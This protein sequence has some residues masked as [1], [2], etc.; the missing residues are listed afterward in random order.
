VFVPGKPFPDL[1]S[2]S[3]TFVNFVE[4]GVVVNPVPTGSC[5]HTNSFSSQLMN[6]PSVTMLVTLDWKSWSGTNN[7][8]HMPIGELQIKW[9]V[10]N[11]VP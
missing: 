7:F 10:V 2:L 8:T 11:T 1:S 3:G 4:N 9:S 5:I 6:M